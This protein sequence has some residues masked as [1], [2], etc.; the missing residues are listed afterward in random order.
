M[1]EASLKDEELGSST[2]VTAWRRIRGRTPR[3][4]TDTDPG[5]EGARS[6]ANTRACSHPP[7]TFPTCRL[8]AT[9]T[10][11]RIMSPRKNPDSVRGTKK[12]TPCTAPRPR[13][14]A[15]KATSHKAPVT[16]SFLTFS[17]LRTRLRTFLHAPVSISLGRAGG[18]V[19][20]WGGSGWAKL[21]T[22]RESVTR[23]ERRCSAQLR[24]RTDCDRAA[25]APP[26]RRLRSLHQRLQL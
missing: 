25:V 8:P 19:V 26:T 3:L 22:L 6:R 16:P 23:R 15:A 4:G 20:G 18:A 9:H 7:C 12:K 13:A 10:G 1:R 24:F 21:R 14:G 11:L 17:T 2:S 5:L